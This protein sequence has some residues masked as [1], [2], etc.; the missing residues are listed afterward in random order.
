MV[1]LWA[2]LLPMIFPNNP[3]MMAA[4]SGANTIVR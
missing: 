2:P 4:S 1:T 3:A